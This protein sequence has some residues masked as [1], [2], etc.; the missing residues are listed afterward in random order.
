MNRE[1]GLDIKV[2]REELDDTVEELR[3]I[4][5]TRPNITI[6]NNKDVYVTIN[7]YGK[8]FDK[9]KFKEEAD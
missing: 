9:M 5:D 3:E 1:V 8:E 7:Y 6:R 2:N 4:T